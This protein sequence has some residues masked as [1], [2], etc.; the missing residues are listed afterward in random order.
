MSM[1]TANMEYEVRLIPEKNIIIYERT[2]WA[3]RQS[4]DLSLTAPQWFILVRSWARTRSCKVRSQEWS[5]E[6]Q[7]EACSTATDRSIY[8]EILD[9]TDIA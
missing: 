6:F 7:T 4:M 8:Q 5:F 1:I 2:Y 3:H 9:D